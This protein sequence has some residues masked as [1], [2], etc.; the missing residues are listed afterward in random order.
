MHLMANDVGCL[1]K[2]LFTICI[3]SSVKC[4]F[5]YFAHFLTGLICFFYAWR[6]RVIHILHTKTLLNMWF[7]NISSQF[8][9]YLFII[10]RKS[11]AE[12]KFWMFFRSDLSIFPFIDYPSENSE[13]SLATPRF[14]RFFI[15]FTKSFKV[16]CFILKAMIHFE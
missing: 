3:S 12:Q 16:L 5:M 2:S 13:N 4:L 7:A 9:A 15:F 8:V 11:L 6:L 1:F 10:Q 14:Q